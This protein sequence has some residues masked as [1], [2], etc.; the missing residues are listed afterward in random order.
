[1]LGGPQPTFPPILITATYDN[2]GGYFYAR[3]QTTM[4]N[5]SALTILYPHSDLESAKSVWFS[6]IPGV[7]HGMKFIQE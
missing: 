5:P 6:W 3:L 4:T 7:T 1:M 2:R